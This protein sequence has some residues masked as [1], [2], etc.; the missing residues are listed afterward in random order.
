M[1]SLLF[2]A[3]AFALPALTG[4]AGVLLAWLAGHVLLGLLVSIGI[5][6][7]R[8]APAPPP[9]YRPRRPAPRGPPA[10]RVAPVPR[11]HPRD[12]PTRIA[13]R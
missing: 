1:P 5:L 7:P 13:R 2:P 4:V 6:R 9:P 3:S 11:V 12:V 8:P 10:V